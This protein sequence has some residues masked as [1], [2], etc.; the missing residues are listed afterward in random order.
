MKG[1]CRIPE[2]GMDLRTRVLAIKKMKWKNNPQKCLYLSS[3]IILFAGMASSIYIY[4][5]AEIP[6]DPALGFEVQVTKK[7]L[8][9]LEVYGGKANVLAVEF[10][11]WFKSL[12]QG[13]SL[14]YTIGCI[15]IL[16]SIVLFLAAYH[17]EFDSETDGQ[18]EN[19]HGRTE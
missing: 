9:D 7:Y 2:E 1:A 10:T 3:A 5:T 18:A 15:T 4:L 16:I 17:W 8:R 19:K 13:Q 11:E 6:S 12:W 14:A